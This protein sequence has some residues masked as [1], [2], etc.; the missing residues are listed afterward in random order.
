MCQEI[1]VKFIL[2]GLKT[3]FKPWVAITDPKTIRFWGMDR[4]GFGNKR[5]K[6]GFVKMNAFGI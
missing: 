1:V 2:G 5:F 6:E 4:F 3:R